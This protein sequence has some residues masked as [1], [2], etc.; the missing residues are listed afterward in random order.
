MKAVDGIDELGLGDAKNTVKEIMRILLVM[1]RDHGL[2]SPDRLSLYEGGSLVVN[3]GFRG[4]VHFALAA[5]E[6]G[7]QR[8]ATA[9]FENG[10]KT[11]I[12]DSPT[13]PEYYDEL[14]Y[15]IDAQIIIQ[16]EKD[17]M[18]CAVQEMHRR[19]NIVSKW[20][21]NT[22]LELAITKHR[23]GCFY[24]VLGQ[25]EQC[26]QAIEESLHVGTGYDEYD[27]LASFKLLATAYDSMHDLDRAIRHYQCAVSMEKTSIT[28]A[29]LMN[30][31]SGEKNVILQL[32]SAYLQKVGLDSCCDQRLFP[33]I[34]SPP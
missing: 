7:L 4:D 2:E 29:R 28:K 31:L 9:I 24:S 23:L 11:G 3:D 21:G 10:A 15:A 25:H 18:N 32:S 5:L 6:K 14:L 27:T 26:A 12:Y 19:L 34:R 1:K 20:L 30:A 33:F 8:S 16:V 13:P 22:S 17:D